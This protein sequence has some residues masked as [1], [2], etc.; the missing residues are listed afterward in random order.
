MFISRHS[1]MGKF[2]KNLVSVNLYENFDSCPPYIKKHLLCKAIAEHGSELIDRFDRDTFNY[3]LISLI[4]HKSIDDQIV[5]QRIYDFF[6]EDIEEIFEDIKLT[7][8]L[9]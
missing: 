9:N 3:I 7:S 2:I 1:N 8:K 4:K 6:E 5:Y